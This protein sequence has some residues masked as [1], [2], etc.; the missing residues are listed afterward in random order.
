MDVF[1]YGCFTCLNNV[2]MTIRD[3]LA[4]PFVCCLVSHIGQT[5]FFTSALLLMLAAT[6]FPVASTYPAN[7]T[8]SPCS[9]I[10]EKSLASD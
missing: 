9:V 7:Q 5:M 6:V 4:A 3:Y 2:D 8:F 10:S 1:T